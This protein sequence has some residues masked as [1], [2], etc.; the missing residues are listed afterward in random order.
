MQEAEREHL[1]A[2]APSH[3]SGP[4]WHRPLRRLAIALAA[5]SIALA[6]ALALGAGPEDSDPPKPLPPGIHVPTYTP[7]VLPFKQGDELVYQAS[8]VGIPAANARIRIAR[9]PEAPELWS[10]QVWIFTNPLTDKLYRMRDYMR[11]DFAPDSLQPSTMLIRQ[12][13]GRRWSNY[14]VTFDRRRELVTMV[15]QG[16][17]GTST[18]RFRSA[19][20]FGMVTGA[21]MALTQPLEVGRTLSLDAFSGTTRYVFD[22]TVTGRDRITTP[23]G[24]F[25]AF[26]VVPSIEYLS[27]GTVNDKAQNTVLWVSADNRRLPLRIQS[28]VFIGYVQADLVNV[29]DGSHPKPA[30]VATPHGAVQTDG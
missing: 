24:T 8:W 23:L 2:N 3:V 14:D 1:I 5:I 10:A 15:K 30:A 17:R 7:G 20:P 25:D 22:L 21:L 12:H 27:G 9:D 13:E 29:I 6:C 19:N 16:P 26:R 4:R 18:Q 28:A 11:E